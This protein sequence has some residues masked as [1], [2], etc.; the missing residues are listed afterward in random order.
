[1]PRRAFFFAVRTGR[2]T[3]FCNYKDIFLETIRPVDLVNVDLR[4]AIIGL[5]ITGRLVPGE[6]FYYYRT[7]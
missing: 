2:I 7:Q 1:M 3:C 6:F 4:A 5:G